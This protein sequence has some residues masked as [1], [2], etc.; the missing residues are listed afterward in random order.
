MKIHTNILVIWE[1]YGHTYNY[2]EIS[3]EHLV[4]K[5]KRVQIYSE[6]FW[7]TGKNKV[8]ETQYQKHKWKE[9]EE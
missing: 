4:G 8:P 2:E 6:P 5:G 9:M 1:A 3:V 7:S